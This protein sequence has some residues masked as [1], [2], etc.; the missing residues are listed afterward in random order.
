[1]LGVTVLGLGLG[2]TGMQ[3]E[4]RKSPPRKG[5]RLRIRHSR[6]RH[7][8]VSGV[9]GVGCRVWLVSVKYVLRTETERRQKLWPEY[10]DFA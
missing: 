5:L 1:M 10:G 4:K 7:V 9:A 3:Y 2:F 6:V 8:R